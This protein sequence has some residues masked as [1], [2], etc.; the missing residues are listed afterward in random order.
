MAFPA[1]GL[2]LDESRDG[3][4]L[5]LSIVAKIVETYAGTIT[6]GPS[7]LGGLAVTVSI[8]MPGVAGA[9]SQSSSK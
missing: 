1:R 9:S 8:P 5:G 7:A 3:T 2:R 6:H 4:G